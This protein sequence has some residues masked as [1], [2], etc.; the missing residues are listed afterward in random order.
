[1][2]RGCGVEKEWQEKKNQSWV[3]QEMRENEEGE[4]KVGLEQEEEEKV[5]KRQMGV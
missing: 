4:Y 2:E 5:G 1:M 3:N